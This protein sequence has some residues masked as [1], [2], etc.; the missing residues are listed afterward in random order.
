MVWVE[1]AESAV[2]YLNRTATSIGTAI[3]PD[4][5][6]I[7]I[8]IILFIILLAF[9]WKLSGWA[10]FIMFTLMLYAIVTGMV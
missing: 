6:E 10:V 2:Q 3:T 7:G 4:K 5:P 9:K 8:F 1:I